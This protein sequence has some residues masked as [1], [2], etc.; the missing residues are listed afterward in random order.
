MLRLA[1]VNPGACFA[2]FATM[3]FGIHCRFCLCRL[4]CAILDNSVYMVYFLEVSCPQSLCAS[5]VWF[6]MP[7][8][9]SVAENVTSCLCEGNSEVSFAAKDLCVLFGQN[10]VTLLLS[11]SITLQFSEIPLLKSVILFQK[12]KVRLFFT[13]YGKLTIINILADNDGRLTGPDVVKL[14]ALS[15]LPRGHLK[16]VSMGSMLF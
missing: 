12:L 3:R 15:Q 10:L 14:F 7:S 8:V 2:S 4:Q 16:Q 13:F 6:D 5:L 11:I 1:Q 9:L